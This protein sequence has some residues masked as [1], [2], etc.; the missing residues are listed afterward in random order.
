MAAVATVRFRPKFS[1]GRRALPLSD[2]VSPMSDSDNPPRANPAPPR[3]GAPGQRRV[4]TDPARYVL[5]LL[6]LLRHWG[7]PRRPVL[8]AAGLDDDWVTRMRGDERLATAQVEPLFSA[9]R[10]LVG[11]SDLA[12]ELGRTLKPTSHGLLGYGLIGSAN[13]DEA[14][15][16]AARQQHHLT[17]S[18]VLHYE[19]HGGGG[20]ARFTPRETMDDERLHFNLELLAVST[21]VTLQMLLGGRVP[22]AQVRLSMPAPPHLA[23]YRE[24]APASFRFEAGAP[25][26]LEITLDGR[27]LTEPLP[28]AAP[29]VVSAIEKHLS[30]LSPQA[31]AE[32]PWARTVEQM[33]RAVNGVQLS[34]KDV[35]ARLGVSARTVDRRLADE[36]R[37]F[38]ELRDAVRLERAR[39]LLA[40]PA[41]S[42]AQV[43]QQL[44]YR[45]A[46]NF[47]RAFRRQ[48]GMPPTAFR[49]HRADATQPGAAA[50]SF[51]TKS[52]SSV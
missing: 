3:D 39:A 26:G 34:V 37:A 2:A 20:R 41:L 9:A 7:M 10:R 43:A 36:G 6:G 46:A 14:W 8:R 31:A 23:R 25:P 27:S 19:R 33:L 49:R 15:Q 17:E 44:G 22:P 13:L 28:M 21:L 38:A 35:A 1:A 11:R 48:A 40:D 51:S 52:K 50:A 24:L 16:L 29:G 18:F 45:D 32:V 5:Q 4:L 42:V 12:F 30:T 47:S